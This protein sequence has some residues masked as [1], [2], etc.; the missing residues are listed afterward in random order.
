MTPKDRPGIV[1]LRAL[2]AGPRLKPIHEVIQSIVA[3]PKPPSSPRKK[4]KPVEGQAA[5]F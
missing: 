5:M 4:R 2:D 1:R 3:V